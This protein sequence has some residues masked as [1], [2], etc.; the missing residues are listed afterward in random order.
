MIDAPR[1]PKALAIVALLFLLEG[2][3][4]AVSMYYSMRAGR[5]SIDLNI[6]SIPTCFGLLRL[7]KG[8]RSYAMFCTWIAMIGYPIASIYVLTLSG[9]LALSRFGVK[10][11]ETTPVHATLACIP[12]FLLSIWQYRV[13]TRGDVRALFG[14]S[15]GRRPLA[16][17]PSASGTPEVG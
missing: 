12:Y 8:W 10:V 2:I 1:V 17:P 14:L 13:L 15:D 6:L 3:W 7:S 16:G 11:G 9:P 5:L 4:A